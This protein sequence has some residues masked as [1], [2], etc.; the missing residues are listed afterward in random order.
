MELYSRRI[1]ALQKKIRDLCDAFLITD[2]INI[3]Y[4]TGSDFENAWIL[5][6]KNK[7][8]G[9]LFTDK[10]FITESKKQRL[11]K[12]FFC[13]ISGRYDKINTLLKS[14][15]KAKLGFENT[16]QFNVFY[17]L[18]ASLKKTVSLI[19]CN[20][21]IENQ[22]TVK[23]DYEIS[24]IK[25]AI[26]IAL[27]T[28]LYAKKKVKEI[29]SAGLKITEKQFA[30]LL[31]AFM[32][33]EGADEIAFKPIVASGE[34]SMDPHAVPGDTIIHKGKIL[35][36]DIG[37]SVNGYKSDLTRTY[38]VG[39]INPLYN[40]RHLLIKSALNLALKKIKVGI[41]IYLVDQ[42]VRKFLAKHGY[43]KYF[44]HSAGH[45]VGLEVHEKPTLTSKNSDILCENMILAIEP[46]IYINGWGGIRLEEMVIVKK[47]RA[48]LLSN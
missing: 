21:L 25:K 47:E 7:K 48:I 16:I 39:R 15:K 20:Q 13:N 1:H 26:K 22:R 31:S 42:E 37:A 30:S 14:T 3:F 19:K 44:L 41:P 38:F 33:Q 2:R 45:G 11:L 34:R 8:N 35:L 29:V 27:K 9:Y 40:M 24:Q 46:G 28:H 10:R 5:L 12:S 32:L 43:E 23:D 18:Q 36:I 4:L 17:E 6:L